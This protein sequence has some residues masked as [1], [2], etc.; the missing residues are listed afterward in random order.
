[1]P[2]VPSTRGTV[3]RS[4][5]VGRL[6]ARLPQ[7]VPSGLQDIGKG[8]QKAGAALEKREAEQE[9]KDQ[10][11]AAEALHTRNTQDKNNVRRATIEMNTE[12]DEVTA[13]DEA[14]PNSDLITYSE[15]VSA[16]IDSYNKGLDVGDP[17]AKEE[18]AL[19]TAVT[20]KQYLSRF[21]VNHQKRV[22]QE[23]AASKAA[24][25]ENLS[26]R[27]AN[28]HER[29]S[30]MGGDTATWMM[31]HNSN[32]RV[33]LW[34][35]T[36]DMNPEQRK[37]FTRSFVANTAS[38]VVAN[39]VGV[40]EFSTGLDR[41]VEA[42]KTTIDGFAGLSDADKSTL[43]KHVDSQVASLRR[44]QALAE[45]NAQNQ[46]KSLIA[47]EAGKL[48][49]QVD[50][51]MYFDELDRKFPA[52]KPLHNKLRAGLKI[53]TSPTTKREVD[54]IVNHVS[55]PD[56][57]KAA[58]IEKLR[59]QGKLSTQDY[60]AASD[61]IQKALKGQPAE[62]LRMLNEHMNFGLDRKALD[63]SLGKKVS[64]QNTLINGWA[65]QILREKPNT[66][67]DELK[68]V[69]G[70]ALNASD[71]DKALMAL[72]DSLSPFTGPSSYLE[73][74]P[75]IKDDKAALEFALKEAKR[76]RARSDVKEKSSLT[77]PTIDPSKM[78][79]EGSHQRT[80]RP[81]EGRAE[82]RSPQ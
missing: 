59:Q 28:D 35:A 57:E 63:R 68:K 12:I 29:L 56:D 60:G 30:D 70:D 7:P 18:F 33:A 50:Q 47:Q 34:D 10:K 61:D 19:N 82:T 66:T 15:K 53:Q 77:T 48:K 11:A 8:L 32:V 49:T 81:H 3:M 46:R 45:R 27:I 40:L 74:L 43:E 9:R 58:R 62:T 76:G 64:Q 36:S 41:S 24:A 78:S 37:V 2:N 20:K 79:N 42:I 31:N 71:S 5:S 21:R 13:E 52:N 4:Q 55:L 17:V 67:L 51:D 72:R 44:T 65:K 73:A 22:R 80:V 26:V 75:D 1:M 23:E 16:I 38:K 14:N 54:D 39:M 6:N 69:L 25:V